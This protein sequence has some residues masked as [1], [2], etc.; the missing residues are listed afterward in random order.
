LSAGLFNESRGCHACQFI[1]GTA[2]K[3]QQCFLLELRILIIPATTFSDVRVIPVNYNYN[4]NRKGNILK[5]TT[6]TINLKQNKIILF[7]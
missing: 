4:Y 7:L 5:G 3:I 1:G 6:G 2:W